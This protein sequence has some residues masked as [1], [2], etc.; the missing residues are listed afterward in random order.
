LFSNIMPMLKKTEH[1]CHKL[2][3]GGRKNQYKFLHGTH[4]YRMVPNT[5]L[6]FVTFSGRT[7]YHYKQEEV[8]L[9]QKTC[10]YSVAG[11]FTPVVCVI[12]HINCIR[13]F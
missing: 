13:L 2:G 3:I 6:V 7:E 9:N 8:E 10:R 4:P 12:I 5:T 11:I 1:R